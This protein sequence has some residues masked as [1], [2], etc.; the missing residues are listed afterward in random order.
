MK[1]SS[2][3]WSQQPQ[4]QRGVAL[5]VA[6]FVLAILSIIAMAVFI[7]A[8]GEVKRSGVARNSEKA[9]K[10]AETGVQLARAMVEQEGVSG[11]VASVDGFSQGGY[12]LASVGSG[13]PG[14]EK[15][16]QWH[17]DSGISGNNVQS[18]ITTPLRPVWMKEAPGRNGSWSGSSFYLNNI[19]E[20]LKF[21][22]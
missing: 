10:L 5:V 22:I 18:E 19:Y 16:E 13:M 2:Q 17:Y 4:S 7:D 8:Q 6:L 3:F 20:K 12:F 9:L 1:Q 15:W 21:F 14:N 11:E